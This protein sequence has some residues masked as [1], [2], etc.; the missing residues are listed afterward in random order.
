MAEADVVA[1]DLLV[2]PVLLLKCKEETELIFV[3]KSG[4]FKQEEINKLIVDKAKQGLKVV[5]LKGGDP[6][7]FGR[8]GEEALALQEAGIPFEVVPGIS[9]AIAVPAYAGIPVTYRHMATSF[10]VVTG[11]EDPNKPESTLD[12]SI[13]AK[14]ETLVVL[15]GLSNLEYVT[16]KLI[17]YKR[18]PETP[19]AMIQKGTMSEQKTVVGTLGNIVEEVYAAKLEAPATLVVGEVVSL[20]EKLEW[21]TVS[22]SEL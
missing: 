1:Y 8:G 2:N 5:R 20:K 22:L 16:L 14:A 15:M 18:S 3:G 4:K 13:L 21:F 17:E 7:V 11:H 9:S 10:T 12:W 19:V 6:F